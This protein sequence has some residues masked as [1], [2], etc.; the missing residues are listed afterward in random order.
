LR[1]N[2]FDSG[3]SFSCYATT[4]L[5]MAELLWYHTKIV[6]SNTSII[7]NF[8]NLAD[9]AAGGAIWVQKR[10]NQG[11]EKSKLELEI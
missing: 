6:G 4:N 8:K 10:Q 9:P 3:T 7:E 1:S 11:F 2:K 5:V